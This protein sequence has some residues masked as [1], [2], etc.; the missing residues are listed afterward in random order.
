MI[1]ANFIGAHTPIDHGD[2]VTLAAKLQC[3]TAIVH[4]FSDLESSGSGF[5]QTGEP[6]ILLEARYF[7]LFAGMGSLALQGWHRRICAVASSD[8]VEPRRGA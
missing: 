3:T 4:S 2:I 7:H 8:A 6:K 1:P 5:L